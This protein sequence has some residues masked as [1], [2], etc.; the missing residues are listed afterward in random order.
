MIWN[1][2]RNSFRAKLIGVVAGMMLLPP[3]AAV[4]QNRSTEQSATTQGSVVIARSVGSGIAFNILTNALSAVFL[5][6]QQ[7]DTVSLVLPARGVGGQFR[8]WAGAPVPGEVLVLSAGSYSV[9]VA[10]NPAESNRQESANSPN[11]LLFLA[12]FN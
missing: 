1:H 7:G 3:A 9:V 12:Q 11:D 4:A 6:G 5:S 2:R 10:A 8:V